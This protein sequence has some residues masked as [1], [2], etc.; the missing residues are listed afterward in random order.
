MP[1]SIV[2]TNAVEVESSWERTEMKIGQSEKKEPW[3]SHWHLSKTLLNANPQRQAS[4]G[5]ADL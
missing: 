1:S 2:C 4:E 3:N 5:G